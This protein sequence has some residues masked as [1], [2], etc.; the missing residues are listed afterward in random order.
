EYFKEE[1]DNILSKNNISITYA[2]KNGIEIYISGYNIIG[3]IELFIEYI[4]YYKSGN[5]SDIKS[6][7]GNDKCDGDNKSD[8]RSDTRND[9]RNNDN[10]INNITTTTHTTTNIINNKFYR[11]SLE[12][13]INNLIESKSGSCYSYFYDGINKIYNKEY[14]LPQEWLDI[15]YNNNNDSIRDINGNNIRDNNSINDSIRDNI[16]FMVNRVMIIGKCKEEE[17]KNMFININNSINY[18]SKCN[19]GNNNI[20]GNTDSNDHNTIKSNINITNNNNTT[21]SN[22]NATNNNNNT[23]TKNNNNSNT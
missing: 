16:K 15:L 5:N 4:S 18:N 1:Y 7:N 20:K 21:N 19:D 8:D 12:N 9:G 6:D 23:I 13:I 10:H 3:I 11:V 2:L 14:K 17:I 22:N